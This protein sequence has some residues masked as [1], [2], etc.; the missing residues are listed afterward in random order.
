MTPVPQTIYIVTA[1]HCPST[2]GINPHCYTITG[3]Y[4]SAQAA[5][6]A[7]F[8]KAK[9]LSQQPVTHWHG[10]PTKGKAEWKESPFKIEFTGEAGD[11]GVCWVDER[12]LG[13]EVVPITK[14]LKPGR[15]GMGHL[16]ETEEFE[17]GMSD[18]ECEETL[19]GVLRF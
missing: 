7:M 19:N 9:E 4:S 1:I 3:A 17:R 2:E 13:V 12:V 18:E 10:H 8:A 14:I 16:G 6:A 11:F 5:Q 15:F